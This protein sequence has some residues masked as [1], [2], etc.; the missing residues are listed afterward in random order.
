MK[1]L[2]HPVTA[3]KRTQY[4]SNP[5]RSSFSRVQII[6]LLCLLIL[7]VPSLSGQVQNGT[8][9]GIITDSA[10]ALIPGANVT[11]RQLATNLILH[12]QTN[13]AGL[14]TFPQLLPGEYAVSVEMQGF[15]KSV[16]NLTLTVGQVA[17]V[18]FAL[19]VGTENQT[20]EVQAD[21]S[22][23][24][25]TQTSNLDY[26]VQ[27]RQMN[28]LPLN[29]RNPYGLAV[30]APGI[31]AGANFGVGVT[32]AR[33]AVVAAATNN[34]QSNGGLGGN[35]NILL[36]GVSIEVCCQGQPA[37]TPSAE[38]V[39]QFKVVSSTPP[40]EY[41]RTSGAV[42]NLVTKSGGNRL[43]GSVYEFLR[44]DKLDAANYF[45]KRN[46]VYPYRGHNDYRAP[47]R[48]NQFGAFV[49]GPVVLPHIYNGIDRTFFTFGYE[50][51]RNVAP[52]TGTA[53]VPTALMRQ[54]IFTEGPDKVY[55][56]T[57]YNPST[58]T[59]TPIAAATCNGTGYGTGYC[60]PA[61]QIDATATKLMALIPAPNLPG[62]VSNYAYA[63][64]VTDKDDQFN[65]R[66]DQNFSDKHRTFVRGTR[67]ANDHVAYDLF[68]KPNGANQGWTQTL[69]S[70]LFA[71]GHLWT[72]T[73]DTLVQFSYGFAR[74]KNLQL[75]SQ[76]LYDA[77]D[78][79]F[80]GNFTS[81]QQSKGLPA[82]SFTGLQQMGFGSY[83]N[84]W[85]H[86]AHSLNASALLQRGRHSLS[87]GYNGQLILENQKG[88]PSGSIG[89][90]NFNTA[91]TNP[92]PNITLPSAQGAFDAWASFLLGYPSGGS[93]ITRSV[94]VAFNQWV[95]GLYAQDDWRLTP[96]LTVNMGLRWDVETGFGERHNHWAVFNPNIA[97]PIPGVS[98]I[99]VQGGAQF[100]G[101]NG[102]PTRT[103]PT[104]YNKVGPRLGLSWSI[105]NSTVVRGGY[106]IL[107]LPISQRGYSAPNIGY[108]QSTNIA[109]SA[110]GFTPIVKTADPFSGGVLLP[111]G[112]SA[113]A[114]VSAGTGISGLQYQNPVSYQQQW[115]FGIEHAFARALT[116]TMNYVG[117]HGVHLPISARPN[118]LQPAYFG[119]VGDT[120]QVSYL[121]QQVPNPFYSVA[122]SLAPG[123]LLRNPT[124]QRAQLLTAFPQYTSGSISGIQNYSVGISY[125]DQG[126][127]TYNA[128]QT[129]LLIHGQGGL[130][131]SVSYVFSKLMGNVSDLT[132]GFLN[133]TGNP[134]I[135]NYYL[136]NQEH[137]VL[138][139]DTPHR[140]TGTIA[141]PIPVGTGKR[142]GG[143]MPGWANKLA[144]DWSVNTIVLINS[145]YPLSFTVTG[146]PAFAG[147]RPMWVPGV[148]PVTSGSVQNRL[149]GTGQQGYLNPGAFALPAAFQL[150]NV[151]RS[152]AQVRG[153]ISFDNS[154]SLIKNIRLHESLSLELRG[155]AFNVLNK[156]AFSMPNAQRGN[157]SF[158]QITSTSNNPRNIQLGARIHF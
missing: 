108:S 6:V 45:V 96:K 68:N 18:D 31:A 74:Q 28:S 123:S 16:M 37:V 1:R 101:A 114:G 26:T 119:A 158:G 113:G 71:A 42:L 133:A 40:A 97:N 126:S 66:L 154:V 82:I 48:S 85:G 122:S 127:A 148:S 32:V 120:S 70:Y 2:R 109:T 29:G 4:P 39:S 55:D 106:G 47:H 14:Y 50:G 5:S 152:T 77:S 62:P 87:I 19:Q 27:E 95:T 81:Q 9:Q 73:P 56:P 76:F 89:N 99:T 23:T 65:F 98:G 118:D 112:A 117:G 10:G 58:Q 64:N 144:G 116:F 75:P 80:S 8:I 38:V 139:T 67:A 151:P 107:Y 115:N 121:Q 156:A 78:Y 128:L 12:D 91:F 30:L 134:G 155:E 129:S 13:G 100:L 136:M 15:K 46:G 11:A 138:A 147:T 36:D 25:N 51:V 57:S 22:A 20:I 52:V 141:L 3:Q 145:G 137:S 72:L 135:Q 21:N 69:S 49:S 130:T 143:G 140:F 153:P 149:G 63:Q 7:S 125:L 79:G 43:H 84:F 150:G 53:T 142:F 105:D 35:N 146:T 86:N 17:H 24:L 88:V 59:R 41:G 54:G 131:G 34:F 61:S 124:V 94:T 110:D 132:N 102:N 83:Y 92:G 90:L 111:V 44:N 157:A 33:G 60:I 104:F 103:S 93:S